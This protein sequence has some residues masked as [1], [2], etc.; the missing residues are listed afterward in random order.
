MW[1]QV[2]FD[3]PVP[4]PVEQRIKQFLSNKIIVRGKVG[5]DKPFDFTVYRQHWVS[6]T[7]T[8]KPR[9]AYS[10]VFEEQSSEALVSVTV[11][12][13]RACD[14]QEREYGATRS[15]LARLVTPSPPS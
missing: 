2:V 6:S 15:P 10:R 1:Y 12:R 4:L 5:S 13:A 14:R 9:A 7:I 3:L 8:I 11:V